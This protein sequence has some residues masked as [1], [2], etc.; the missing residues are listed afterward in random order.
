MSQLVSLLLSTRSAKVC[1]FRGCQWSSSADG[2]TLFY[3]EKC[4]TGHFPAASELQ[5]VSSEIW[6]SLLP[7]VCI[8]HHKL[9][10]L[11]Y[12]SLSQAY[13]AMYAD[14]G[15]VLFTKNLPW[16]ALGAWGNVLLPLLLSQ[17]CTQQNAALEVPS[18]LPLSSRDWLMSRPAWA[19]HMWSCMRGHFHM[20]WFTRKQQ[21]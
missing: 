10:P 15:D 13:V 4:F 5:P 1:G 17:R 16:G 12:I 9:T 8:T 19:S 7:L 2:W 3:L 21:I 18:E 11:V 6:G 14:L 20:L